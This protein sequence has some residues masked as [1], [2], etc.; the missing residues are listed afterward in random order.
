[1]FSGGKIME[2]NVGWAC[3][4]KPRRHVCKNTHC[5]VRCR[6]WWVGYDA[7]GF[8]DD[9]LDLFALPFD[10]FCIFLLF[11]LELTL[12]EVFVVSFVSLFLSPGEF[13]VCFDG[14]ALGFCCTLLAAVV[15]GVL[16]FNE[17]RGVAP[18]PW[19]FEICRWIFLVA[20]CILKSISF[21]TDSAGRFLINCHDRF[22]G[23]IKENSLIRD[24]W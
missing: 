10:C 11:F 3:K 19:F 2:G 14:L 24:F 21:S 17:A 5:V 13:F 8:F 7:I 22:F 16:F 20:C 18:R 23:R 6:L 15:L 1:M 12:K 4:I 9:V